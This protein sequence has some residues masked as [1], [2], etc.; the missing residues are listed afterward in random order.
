MTFGKGKYR[1]QVVEDWGRGQEGYEP[2]GMIT[3]VAV[4]SEDRL[5][6]FRRTPESGVLVYDREGRF[7][8]SW[9]A[10]IFAEP[11]AIWVSE[12]NEA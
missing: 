12:D 7:L 9:G 2:G 6:A 4:D 10:G 11:H 1:Y 5:Y 3:G 8:A